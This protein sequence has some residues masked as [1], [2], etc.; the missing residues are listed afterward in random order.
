MSFLSYLNPPPKVAEWN[1]T[2]LAEAQ[3]RYETIEKKFKKITGPIALIF[4]CF[5]AYSVYRVFREGMRVS[6]FAPLLGVT[7]IVGLISVI[8]EGILSANSPEMRGYKAPKGDSATPAP[9][10]PA[11]AARP[12]STQKPTPRSPLRKFASN[13]PSR[14]QSDPIVPQRNASPARA[15]PLE[16]GETTQVLSSGLPEFELPPASA[17]ATPSTPPKEET[18]ES[19]LDWD[20]SPAAGTPTNIVGARVKPPA[21]KAHDWNA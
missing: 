5:A 20:A 21:N 1:A 4:V 13:T 18:S 16:A 19:P 17:T 11:P 7:V 3:T 14:T 15:N 10:T 2:T 6:V 9:A 12:E 8:L